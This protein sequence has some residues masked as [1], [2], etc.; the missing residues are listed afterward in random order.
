MLDS[1][2]A[3]IAL[4]VVGVLATL[5]FIHVY[6]ALRGKISS[7]SV[8][9]SDGKPAFTPSRSATLLVAFT[10][11]FSAYVVAASGRL[12]DSPLEHWPRV[13]TFGLSI[14]FLVRSLGDFRLVG[15]FKRP[16]TSRFARL[17]TMFYSPLCLGLG[18]ATAYVAY[19]DV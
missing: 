2:P 6:W 11:L 16:S 17:D 10:L 4:L 7:A 18:L 5:G 19:H 1:M 9:E 13:A 12:V 8:P 3:V 15:F 14:V